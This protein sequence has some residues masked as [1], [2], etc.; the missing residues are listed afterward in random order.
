MYLSEQNCIKQSFY[1]FNFKIIVLFKTKNNGL[2]G[3]KTLETR[4]ENL[5]F[6]KEQFF[7][8]EY[9]RRNRIFKYLRGKI[10]KR[11]F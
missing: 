1:I 5:G 9:F 4:M 11:Y 7:V 2:P 6:I 10:T 8:L 3:I